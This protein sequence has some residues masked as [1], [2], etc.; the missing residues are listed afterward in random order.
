MLR[1]LHF[2]VFV[3]RV[4]Y[5]V[6]RRLVFF[7]AQPDYEHDDV[8]YDED[9]DEGDDIAGDDW[10]NNDKLMASGRNDRFINGRHC[11]S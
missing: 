8:N 4:P 5:L 2:L 10:D 9:N 1:V 11:Q 3:L 7:L 6:T